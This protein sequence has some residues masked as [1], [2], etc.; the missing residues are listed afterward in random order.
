M[1]LS[2]QQI[3]EY[4]ESKFV[5]KL[6]AKVDEFVREVLSTSQLAFVRNERG[7]LIPASVSLSNFYK[8]LPLVKNALRIDSYS[9]FIQLFFD[10]LSAK[11]MDL[12]FTAAANDLVADHLLA[13]ENFNQVIEEIRSRA[14][15]PQFR[16]MAKMLGKKTR[17]REKSCLD[18]IDNLHARYARLAIVR[19]DLHYHKCELGED[20]GDS[21]SDAERLG[22]DVAIMMNNG[23][24]KPSIFG[25]KVGHIFKLEC[26][27][28][29]GVHMHCIFFFDGAH[30]IKHAW[31]GEQIGMYWRETITGGNGTF[32]NC[33]RQEYKFPAIGIVNHSDYEKRQNMRRL[34]SYLCKVE[35]AVEADE[36]GMRL[37]RRGEISSAHEKEHRG[38]RRKVNHP[39]KM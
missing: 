11:W 27:H 33:N 23:R 9:L 17:R 37:L 26:G 16:E 2:A 38:R 5:K 20:A 6:L 19:I 3:D 28:D 8:E 1:L 32:H 34:I 25:H 4:Q 36:G 39:V 13:G 31:R 29:R 10:V 18:Y 21:L 22:R 7:R 35:Q 30:V 14:A 12:S 24:H 15:E